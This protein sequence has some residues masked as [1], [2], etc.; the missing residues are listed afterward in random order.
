MRELLWSG[1]NLGPW[2]GN[3]VNGM[4]NTV[5]ATVEAASPKHAEFALPDMFTSKALRNR[6]AEHPAAKADRPFDEP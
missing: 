2:Q 1:M 5:C 4:I 6:V 3:Y